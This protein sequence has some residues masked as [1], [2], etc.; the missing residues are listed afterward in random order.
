[1]SLMVPLLLGTAAFG[2]AKLAGASTK[3][4]LLAGLG[5]FGG[6]AAFQSMAPQTYSSIFGK[7][8]LSGS[9]AATTGG[10]TAQGTGMNAAFKAAVGSSSPELAAAAGTTSGLA[11]GAPIVGSSPAAAN[12]MVGGQLGDAFAAASP[13]APEI[14]AAAPMAADVAAAPTLAG[15]IG[16]FISE[17][18]GTSLAGGAIATNLL[19]QA[20]ADDPMTVQQ[21]SQAYPEADYVR[22]K[23][24]QDAAVEGMAGRYP[25]NLDPGQNR[26][27]I[28]NPVNPIYANQGGLISFKNYSE[29]G[30][31]YLPS[32]TDHDENDSN[33]YVRATGYVEDGTGNGDKDEDTMLA[34]LADGEFVSR[35]DAI[36][37]AG[38]MSGANPEDMKEMRRKGARFFYNQQDQLKR[39]YDIV[40]DGNKTS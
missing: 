30:I 15:K 6:L 5:T 16:N 4:S 14:A 12:Y 10:L 29:G 8:A 26:G 13:M 28:Y 36:L 24:E 2:I 32:K 21:A 20:M 25:Y 40:N 37:G 19:G 7:G 9:Q 23:Q 22:L 11:G 3:T 27:D 17:N 18:P 34:Q 38:I 33:N 35:A 39:I 31:N 1:M